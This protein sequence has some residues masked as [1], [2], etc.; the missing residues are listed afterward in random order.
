MGQIRIAK[1]GH[2]YERRR[3]YG[4]R[5]YTVQHGNSGPQENPLVGVA[6]ICVALLLAIP[7]YGISLLFMIGYVISTF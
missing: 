7:T 5:F 6:V 2:R 3:T 4:G 1:D